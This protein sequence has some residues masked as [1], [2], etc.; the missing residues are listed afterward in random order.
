MFIK[1]KYFTIQQIKLIVLDSMSTY[2]RGLKPQDKIKHAHDIAT[3]LANVT[4]NCNCAVV[5]TNEMVARRTPK[6]LSMNKCQNETASYLS[7]MRPVLGQTFD[8]RCHQRIL[9]I[10]KADI[11]NAHVVQ[12]SNGNRGGSAEIKI[13]PENHIRDLNQ[14]E[15]R[16]MKDV[17][18]QLIFGEKYI[19]QEEDFVGEESSDSDD[20]ISDFNFE[21]ELAKTD[22]EKFI[23]YILNSNEIAANSSDASGCSN[24]FDFDAEL[25]IIEHNAQYSIIEYQTNQGKKQAKLA[26]HDLERVMCAIQKRK[27]DLQ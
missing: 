13:D 17:Y 3:T 19:F 11:I 5:I 7:R 15:L 9:L 1:T 12:A 21:S 22:E 2:L 8:G 25:K 18:E 20:S 4:L 24:S 26:S 14:D 27:N 23:K 10:K 6:K 16:H